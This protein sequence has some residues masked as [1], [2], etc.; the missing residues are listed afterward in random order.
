MILVAWA[1][2][3]S[4]L[5]LPFEYIAAARL[6]WTISTKRSLR[7]LDEEAVQFP[8]DFVGLG[9]FEER[10]ETAFRIYRRCSARLDDINEE[11]SA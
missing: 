4:A 7:E 1:G 6:D 2:P 9:G 11:E 10:F 8:Y 3:K 5:K